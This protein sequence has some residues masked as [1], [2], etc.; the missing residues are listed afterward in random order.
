[1]TT[2]TVTQLTLSVKQGEVFDIPFVIQSD[3]AIKDLTGATI[4][5]EVKKTPL[6]SASAIISKTI[7]ED[8]D[9]D[10]IGQITYPTSGQFQVH[11]DST[12]TG[13]APYDYYLIITLILN[14]QEDII[15]SIGNKKA[16]YR[17]CTQ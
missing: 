16:V 2:T 17:I 10:T 3:G 5:F 7:T 9:I 8:S 15:S 13:Y 12:D 14:D 6:A 4:L 11:L 1:M